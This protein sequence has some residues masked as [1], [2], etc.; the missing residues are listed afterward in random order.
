MMGFFQ[1]ICGTIEDAYLGQVKLGTLEVSSSGLKLVAMLG[2][3]L[4]LLF[5]LSDNWSGFLFAGRLRTV[6]LH[7]TLC[8]SH[9]IH[10]V[11]AF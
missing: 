9:S 11:F 10:N 2:I 7:G 5:S 4:E 6:P 3:L 8:N 1:T